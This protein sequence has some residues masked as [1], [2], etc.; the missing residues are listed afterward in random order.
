[1]KAGSA[2][3]IALRYLLGRAREGGRYL[4]GA[5]AGIALSLVPIIITLIVADGM[6]RG[7]IGRYLELGTGH[8][9][10]FNVTDRQNP[11]AAMAYL[12]GLHGIRGMW[13]ERQGLG[14]LLGSEGSRGASIRAVERTFWEDEGSARYL[15]T[16]EGV[17][18]FDSDSDVLLGSELARSIGASVGS[19]VRI[20]TIRP[21][22]GGHFVPRVAAFTVRGI[23]SSGYR[24][25]DAMWC[26]ITLEAGLQILPE[27]GAAHLI[28]KIDDP[29]D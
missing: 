27:T 28:V 18:A 20:M 16:L 1:M 10:V 15:E 26:I 12:E 24:E 17:A 7:I 2:F 4:R 6:I 22:P 14:V 3:F 21:I 19:M 11:E 25:L 13:P 8:L 29:F 9:Q 5:A 23:V